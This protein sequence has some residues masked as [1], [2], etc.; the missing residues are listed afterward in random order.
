MCCFLVLHLS[1]TTR[2]FAKMSLCLISIICLLVGLANSH[3]CPG[4]K[5]CD[6]GVCCPQSLTR[7]SY[8]CCPYEF[9]CEFLG[10]CYL[11]P[12]SPK[13]DKVNQIPPSDP[14]D[15][16]SLEYT[17]D[18]SE[19]IADVQMGILGNIL[20]KVGGIVLNKI[21]EKIFPSRL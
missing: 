12:K 20:K 17:F 16:S 13:L 21:K 4:G 10:G 8:E 18:S 7:L 5:L 9:G 6:D 1:N 15:E 19:E 3:T 14:K 11:I 2:H